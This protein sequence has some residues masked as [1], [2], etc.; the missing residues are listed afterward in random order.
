MATGHYL[1]ACSCWESQSFQ[2]V[3]WS[4]CLDTDTFR[5]L[6]CHYVYLICV[7]RWLP[8]TSSNRENL[9]LPIQMQLSEKPKTFLNLRNFKHFEKKKEKKRKKMIVIAQSFLKYW[10]RITCF[11]KCIKGPVFVKPLVVN[12][13][14][15]FV[16]GTC[17][18]YSYKMNSSELT[19]SPR[20]IAGGRKVWG[21]G[22]GMAFQT[23]SCIN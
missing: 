3:L 9:P 11:F 17:K 2:T 5:G 1:T 16:T 10:L 7:T 22:G 6:A 21:G 15:I 13:S 12:V 4:I 8:T 18:N 20:L 23:N 19:F 14:K